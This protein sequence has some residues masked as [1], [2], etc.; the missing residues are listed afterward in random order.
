MP[1]LQITQ[2]HSVTADEAKKRIQTLATELSDKYGLSSEW[3]SDTQAE[4]KRTGATGLIS[5][6]PNQVKVALD[7]S[8]VLSPMKDKIEGKIKE[9]L[10]RLF[11]SSRSA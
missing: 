6:E 3:K 8:F 9:E 5:I 4:V 10:Q 7:L 2:S 11:G 1:K